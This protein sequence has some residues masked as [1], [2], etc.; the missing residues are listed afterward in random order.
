MRQSG[1]IAPSSAR[2]VAKGKTIATRDSTDPGRSPHEGEITMRKLN[3]T[4]ATTVAIL[5]AGAL[6]T[7]ASAM[8]PASAGLRAAVEDA[9]VV[10]K[11]HTVCTHF[12][13]GHWHPFEQCY[14]V[15][16]HHHHHWRRY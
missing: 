8:T 9:T 7:S 2:T 12:W 10:D 15:P 11:V 5:S 4:I 16:N 1:S 3:L 14:W 13:N 6:A